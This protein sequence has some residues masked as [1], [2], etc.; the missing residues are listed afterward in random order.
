M[1]TDQILAYS[2]DLVYPGRV[3]VRSPA[4]HTVILPEDAYWSISARFSTAAGWPS[5][6]LLNRLKSG[7]TVAVDLANL[8]LPAIQLSTAVSASSL[9]GDYIE[10]VVGS[11]HDVVLDDMGIYAG[12]LVQV[13]HVGVD[14]VRI[15]PRPS[16]LPTIQRLN[17]VSTIDCVLDELA[18]PSSFS[19]PNWDG[20]TLNLRTL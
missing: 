12:K 10:L 19:F 13:S 8:R 20:I 14:R 2:V 17:P 11:G 9:G 18:Q 3:D 1:T 16:V 6:G 15:I 5:Q 4:D 7:Q